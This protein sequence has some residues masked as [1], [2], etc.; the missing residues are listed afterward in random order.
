MGKMRDRCSLCH[1]GREKGSKYCPYHMLALKKLEEAYESW[2]KALDIEWHDF[3]G[4]VSER[5]ETGVWA[6]DVA[7]SLLNAEES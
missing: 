3:I 1:R 5:P 4:I 6:K 7:L 2:R